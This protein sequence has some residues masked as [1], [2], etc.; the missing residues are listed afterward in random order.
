MK[1]PGKT[2]AKASAKPTPRKTARKPSTRAKTPAAPDMEL[3][4]ARIQGEVEKRRAQLQADLEINGRMNEALV[5]A[6]GLNLTELPAELR[7]AID[8][9]LERIAADQPPPLPK[10]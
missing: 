3:T 5:R 6:A 8:E 1:R 9:Q 7:R 2:T 4:R 10:G